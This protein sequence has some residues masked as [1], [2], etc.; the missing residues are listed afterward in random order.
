MTSNM[1]QWYSKSSIMKDLAQVTGTRMDS[2]EVVDETPPP[3]RYYNEDM[4]EIMDRYGEIM[5][6]NVPN[7]ALTPDLNG[8]TQMLRMVEKETVDQSKYNTAEN[9]PVANDDILTISKLNPEVKEFLPGG[10]A[11]ENGVPTTSNA[12]IP[13][14]ELKS[15]P[16]C[17]SKV[18][19]EDLP[20]ISNGNEKNGD[21]ALPA[22]NIKE[23]REQLKT[24]I[25]SNAN[26]NCVKSKREKNIAIASLLKLCLQPPEGNSQNINGDT[27]KAPLKLL[28]PDYYETTNIKDANGALQ[29]INGA[30]DKCDEFGKENTVIGL[31]KLNS[32]TNDNANMNGI[33]STTN[34]Q[35]DE[36][37][38][39]SVKK[40]ENWLARVNLE[41]DESPEQIS[42]EKDQSQ[43]PQTPPKK[44]KKATGPPTLF[45]GPVTFKK[46]EVVKSNSP[47]ISSEATTRKTPTSTYVP[48][49]YASELSR[50]YNERAKAR[51]E[52]RDDIFSRLYKELDKRD[53][54]HKKKLAEAELAATVTSDQDD[55]DIVSNMVQITEP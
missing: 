49:A 32:T 10:C 55:E 2:I 41:N 8:I 35:C 45:L 4:S 6:E 40:V 12:K 20:H 52:I 43:S 28:P 3:R 13:S 14:K 30:S 33:V 5:T 16:Q 19:I 34:I 42:P 36:D 17:N 1:N 9:P 25:S 46:K 38:Q 18:E 29:E 23:M 51:N 15:S 37:V 21:T 39:D 22:N 26:R 44:T 11:Q 47:S 27:N 24:K 48:S 31:P 54:A 53:E 7:V 50:S